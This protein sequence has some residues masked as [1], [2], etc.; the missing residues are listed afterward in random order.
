M[1]ELAGIADP[2][3]FPVDGFLHLPVSG[4]KAQEGLFGK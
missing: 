4:F 1:P 2:R 3:H